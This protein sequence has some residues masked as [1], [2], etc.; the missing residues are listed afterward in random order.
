MVGED[1]VAMSGKEMRWIH[2]I[3]QVQDQQLTQGEA[4]TLLGLTER[5]IRRLFRRVDQGGDRGRIH[6]GRGKQSNRPI[7][8]KGRAFYRA[9]PGHSGTPYSKTPFRLMKA[10]P[11]SLLPML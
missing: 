5:R 6:R 1:T 7:P 9:K 8:E 4:D 2:V 11:S 10:A 3:R